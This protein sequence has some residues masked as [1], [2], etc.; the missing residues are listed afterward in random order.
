MHRI[1][2]AF[3]LTAG[4][5]ALAPA[6]QELTLEQALELPN[7]VKPQFARPQGWIDGARY[8]AYDRVAGGG[9]AKALLAVDAATGAAAPF[10]D[11]AKLAKALVE[12]CGIPADR[13]AQWAAR[14]T[15]GFS[16][17]F[18]AVLFN[19]SNDLFAVRL[20]GSAGARL[21]RDAAEEVGQVFAPDASR[22]AYVKDHNLW[23]S[24]VATG[25]ELKLT[26]EGGDTLY[27]GRLD[28]V[29][30]EEI[31]G[32]GNW[33]GFFWSPD[34]R[35]IAFL[36]LDEREVLD[37]TIVDHRKRRPDVEHWSY[38]KAGDANPTA[39]LGIVD[40]TGG[41]I[42]WADLSA[43]QHDEPLLVRVTW[44][45]DSKE[46][47]V[48]VQNREQTWLDLVAIDAATGASRRILRDQTGV[49]IEP[50]ETPIFAPDGESFVWISE[51]DGWRHLYRY[52]RNG[53]PLKR[54]TSGRW[55]VD[56]VLRVTAGAVHFLGDKN[57]VKGEQ[58][59]E[60]PLDGGE[61]VLRSSEPGTHDV[62][63]SPAGDFCV[64]EWSALADAGQAVVR[65]K[66]GGVLRVLATG[67]RDVFQRFGLTAPEFMK[68]KARDG[69]E[70]EG[71]LIKPKGFQEQGASKRWPLFEYAY[72][73]PHHP[74]A[75]DRFGNRMIFWFQLLAQKGYLVWCCDNRSA[76]GRGLDSVKG[77]Y[78]N[79][80]EQ[81]LRDLEDGVAALVEKGLADP[82]R[83]GLFGWSYGG[84][85]T[86]Y[87]LTHSTRFKMGIAGA[88]VTDFRLYDSIYT[89]RYM[90]V[91][92]RNPEGY[93]R[94]SVTAK[95]KDLSGKLL[96][97][98]GVIDENVHL[99]NTLQFAE[100]LQRAQKD[101]RLMLYPGNRH[102][103]V[104]PEQ[105]RH[106][107]GMM[108]AFVLENL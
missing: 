37:Y 48:Q 13:A 68:V 49:W 20:D 90:D 17:K 42:T 79:L 76:S 27:I 70:L 95:A 87:A 77:V 78:R 72:G 14:E 66:D 94:T 91:P 74:E 8:L 80:G 4:C 38:P 61:P 106:L 44:T 81:E 73:G 7:T 104:D 30:Q 52:T 31:Y 45:P 46:A 6:Q 28:W 56:K 51:R 25:A 3:A 5:A 69:A 86:S 101:F 43:Y 58:W 33:Q 53:D 93:A 40:A 1:A 18:D 19:E 62:S 98:H 41:K 35:R 103:V 65:G 100:A 23:V 85:M 12:R 102:S 88:P 105:K 59:F 36:A 92:A 29:Y 54:L 71:Y 99:Q 55:E 10:F 83:I 16:P 60:V 9:D 21:T 67:D 97:I 96:L 84:Y 64:D 39:R 24:D 108:T 57:D 107:Y 26:Q 22:V 11:P 34:A 63:L 2:L 32:R 50:S 15:L 82:A 89:E 47:W 75:L